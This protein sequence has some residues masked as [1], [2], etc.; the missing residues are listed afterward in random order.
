MEDIVARRAR[1]PCY[2]MFNTL[3]KFAN[4]CKRL[5]KNAKSDDFTC[6]PSSSHVA[7]QDPKITKDFFLNSTISFGVPQSNPIDYQ[8]PSSLIFNI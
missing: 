5:I 6:I 3:I 4:N 7:L 1:H 2:N 8:V